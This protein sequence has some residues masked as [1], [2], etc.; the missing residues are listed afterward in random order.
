MLGN[1]EISGKDLIEAVQLYLQ[2]KR[3]PRILVKVTAVSPE[4][5]IVTCDEKER[6]DDGLGSHL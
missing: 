4:S 5:V 6:K 1:I 2:K 3:G